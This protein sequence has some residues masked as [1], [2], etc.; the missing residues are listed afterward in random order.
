MTE[1]IIRDC[2]LTR[3]NPVAEENR[4]VVVRPTMDTMPS[5]L[6][7]PTAPQAAVRPRPTQLRGRWAW[8]WLALPVLML[9]VLVLLTPR[10]AR[11]AEAA[12]DTVTIHV[13]AH[14]WHSG[15]VIPAAVIDADA[16]PARREFPDADH[17]EVGW[18][19]RSYYQ[20][21]DPSLWVGLRA[22]FWPSP[23]VLH[24]VALQGAPTRHFAGARMAT[25]DISREAAQRLVAAIAASHERDAQGQPIA[26]GPSLYGQGRFYG[27]VERFHLF[28]T[29]NV[30]VASRL[31]DAGVAVRPALAIT[32]GMLFRQLPPGTVRQP[33]PLALRPAPTPSA[34]N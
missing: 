28:N 30:W 12:P 33:G 25:L 15:L 11:A 17:F 18:G 6:P 14:G 8:P 20:A 27:S 9:L 3:V 1:R 31:R 13:V 24:M 22:L 26:F 16:W 29:C 10:T 4:V 23:G 7:P 32:T 21:V 5:A 34:E 19:D 2:P